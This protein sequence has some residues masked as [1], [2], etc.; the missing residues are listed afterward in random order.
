MKGRP[1]VLSYKRFKRFKA[2]HDN[3]PVL[4][5]YQT[6]FHIQRLIRDRRNKPLHDHGLRWVC[7]SFNAP[8]KLC[9]TEHGNGVDLN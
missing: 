2:L 4:K 5:R 6:I 7:R 9:V 8:N 3:A 1:S